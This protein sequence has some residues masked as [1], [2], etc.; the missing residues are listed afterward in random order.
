[1]KGNER[2]FCKCTGSKRK[3]KKNAGPLLSGVGDLMTK[4]T[5]M[6]EVLN[7]FLISVFTGKVCLLDSLRS[8]GL[9]T[10][11]VRVKHYPL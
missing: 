11:S 8:P 6:A 2:C 3:A 5:Q 1:M 7:A 10:E 4:G 9:L